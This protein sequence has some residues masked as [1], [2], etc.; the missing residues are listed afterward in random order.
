MNIECGSIKL[1]S[2]TDRMKILYE[3]ELHSPYSLEFIL[4]SIIKVYVRLAFS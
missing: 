4:I 3:F 1:V 2:M